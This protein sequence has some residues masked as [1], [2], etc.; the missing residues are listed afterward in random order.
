[1][2]IGLFACAAPGPSTPNPESDRNNHLAQLPLVDAILLGE[3][4]DAPEHQ[5]IHHTVVAT[6]ASRQT[7]AAL[8]L[9]MATHGHSTESLGLG[10]SEAEVRTALQWNNQA[11]P[12]TAYGPAVM[13]AVRAGVPVIGANLPTA[14]LRG[15]MTD[16][17]LDGRLS[18]PALQLQ[19]Q[20]IRLGHCNA[21]PESQIAPMTRVQVARDVSMAQA[22]ATAVRPGKTVVL[23]AGGGH[24]DR[25]LGVPLHLPKAL[26]VKTILLQ[27]GPASPSTASATGFD[28][29]WPT[30]PAPAVDYC[31]AFSSRREAPAL[32]RI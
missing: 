16:S 31:A 18:G 14:I 27:A 20:R 19:Q 4:H 8:V 15:A 10:S 28:H 2:T 13:A 29:V 9:E 22:V 7:L 3:Q 21:L 17:T 1:M 6:L 12:W 26:T 24:V 11:W 23:L 5:R 30:P 32:P 25:N